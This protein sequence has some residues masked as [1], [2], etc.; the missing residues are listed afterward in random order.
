MAKRRPTRRAPRLPSRKLISDVVDLTV[1]Y[2]RSRDD[3]WRLAHPDDAAYATFRA[4]SHTSH[5]K[6]NGTQKQQVWDAI[7]VASDYV[8]EHGGNPARIPEL[9][10][11]SDLLTVDLSKFRSLD[12]TESALRALLSELLLGGAFRVMVDTPERATADTIMSAIE[13]ATGEM[14]I[15]QLSDWEHIDVELALEYGE[16]V[17]TEYAYIDEGMEGEPTMFQHESLLFWVSMDEF[18]AEVLGFVDEVVYLQDPAQ[19]I[20]VYFS[21]PPEWMFESAD[22]YGHE[23]DWSD[24]SAAW[25]DFMRA[26]IRADMGYGSWDAYYETLHRLRESSRALGIDVDRGREDQ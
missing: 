25:R 6:A 12:L 9:A 21:D 19:H 10:R 15:T 23:P 14:A 4:G 1:D 22:L 18:E 8:M 2:L 16:L 7:E 11:A 26:N 13:R 20:D 5:V 24:L 3:G 17:D